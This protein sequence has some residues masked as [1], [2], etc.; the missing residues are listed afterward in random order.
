MNTRRQ[1]LATIFGFA[2]LGFA[3]LAIIYWA[4]ILTFSGIDRRARRVARSRA[5]NA[6]P[7]GSGP[8]R[9]R[10]K[11][12]GTALSGSSVSRANWR[13]SVR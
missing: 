13:M 3:L 11:N 5:V 9:C 8:S 4:V 12:S 6:L 7:S 2:A 1:L 10:F